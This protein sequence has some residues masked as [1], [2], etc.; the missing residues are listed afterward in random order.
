MAAFVI[1]RQG[2]FLRGIYETLGIVESENAKEQLTFHH[3]SVNKKAPYE[4]DHNQTSHA[5]AL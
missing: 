4:I 3:E 5:M 2:D 1:H